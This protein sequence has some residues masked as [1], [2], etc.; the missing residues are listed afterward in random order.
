MNQRVVTAPDH[1]TWTCIQADAG[2]SGEDPDQVEDDRPDAE[3]HVPV[4]C[5][6]SGGAPSLCLELAADWAEAMP[7]AELL[8]V[9]ASQ[10]K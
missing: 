3:G 1:T 4:I 10:Q 5:T 9:I 6:A 7:D 2:G 8:L